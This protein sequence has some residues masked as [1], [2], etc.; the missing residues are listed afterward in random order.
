[1]SAVVRLFEHS[2]ALPL[3]G[4]G[5]KTDLFQSCGNC[6]VFQIYLHIECSTFTASSF[7]IWNS[8]T[9][10]PSPLALFVVMLS[11]ACLTSHP[12]MSGY[13]WVITPSW[14]SGSWRSFL[15]SSSV[16][17]CH[18]FLIYLF[19][20][21]PYHFCPYCAYLC[22]KCSL[23]ILNFLE[24]TCSLSHSIVFLCFFA[25]ITE[26]GVL[27]SPFYSLEL[28]IQMLI[29]FPFSFAFHFSYFISYLKGLLRQPFC[30]TTAS[31]TM[32]QNS[33]HSSS[34]N[35]SDLIPWIHLSLS[36]YNRKGLSH[37][38]PEWSSGFPYS[39]Q[40]KSEFGNK[41]FMIWATVS[42]WSCFCWLTTP[43]GID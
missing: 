2:L 3:F 29:S 1:M 33:V 38:I 40:L 12:R 26:E 13:R 39:L 34:G 9:G 18:L 37:I 17:S 6:W 42:S 43:D 30:L 11:K 22:R 4:I 25:L 35:L 7:R 28:C 36:L 23:G 15:Y 27:I 5:M 32:S 19:L 20:L 14:W 24:E 41:E 21:G 8:S 10:I 31:C 16:Y